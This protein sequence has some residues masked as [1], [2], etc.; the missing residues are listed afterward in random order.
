MISRHPA[1]AGDLTR[2]SVRRH[3]SSFPRRIDKVEIYELRSQGSDTYIS[4]STSWRPPR[5]CSACRESP[6]VNCFIIYRNII[7]NRRLSLFYSR[8]RNV[9]WYSN[10][11]LSLDN[12]KFNHELPWD[13]Y[14]IAQRHCME[15]TWGFGSNIDPFNLWLSYEATTWTESSDLVSWLINHWLV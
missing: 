10:D 4:A 7:R 1:L 13:I 15:T 6:Y 14:I 9:T 11:I 8:S 12:N 3:L 5:N 2:C